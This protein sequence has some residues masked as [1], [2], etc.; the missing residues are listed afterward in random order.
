[1]IITQKITD[2]EVLIRFY[3]YADINEGSGDGGKVRYVWVP[4][5]ALEYKR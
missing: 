3:K 4:I 2:K 5:Q 1:M